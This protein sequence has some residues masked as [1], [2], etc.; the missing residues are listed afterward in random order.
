MATKKR[1]HVSFNYSYCKRCGICYWLCPTKTITKGELGKP[2]VID[3]NTC[4]GCLMCEN[5]CPD[6]AID[7]QEVS[8]AVT[9][10]A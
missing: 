2:Q 5:S 1:Y 7:I 9:E 8:E 4:I 6:F 3:H 10:N